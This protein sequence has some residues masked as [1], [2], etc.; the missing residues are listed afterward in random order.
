MVISGSV[1][2]RNGKPVRGARVY[3]VQAPAS[4]PDIAAL[5]GAD[6]AYACSVPRAGDYAIGCSAE[7]FATQVKRLSIVT[8][9]A[10][11]D[12]DLV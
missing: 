9:G 4:V 6:G 5:S 12:F 10:H 1:R 2:D 7:G 8:T 11:L 3:V